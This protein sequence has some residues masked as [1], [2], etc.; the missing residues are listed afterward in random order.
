MLLHVGPPK[1][2]RAPFCG[3][4]QTSKDLTHLYFC[5]P[6]QVGR[7]GDRIIICLNKANRG[8]ARATAT[9]EGGLGRKGEVANCGED[10]QG[11]ISGLFW[12]KPKWL[13]FEVMLEAL[14]RR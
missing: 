8:Y 5:K 4:T 1:G 14:S 13:G 3:R 6:V 9:R 7:H 12:L 2:A 10:C 11:S